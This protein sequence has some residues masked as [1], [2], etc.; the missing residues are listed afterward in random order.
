[1]EI[2]DSVDQLH[3]CKRGELGTRRTLWQPS[4]AAGEDDD[5]PGLVGGS[6]GSLLFVAMMPS[7][8]GTSSGG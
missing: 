6:N 1:L 7:I 4:R 2:G 5:P 3:C 8:V